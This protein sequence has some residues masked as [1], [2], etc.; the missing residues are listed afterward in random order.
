MTRE[1]RTQF[2]IHVFPYV[3][4]PSPPYSSAPLGGMQRLAGQELAPHHCCPTLGSSFKPSDTTGIMRG[5]PQ[6]SPPPSVKALGYPV[7]RDLCDDG[8]LS[9]WHPGFS[10]SRWRDEVV[11]VPPAPLGCC[12]VRAGSPTTSLPT[13]PAV[14][15]RGS[16]TGQPAGNS[17]RPFWMIP[18]NPA[19]FSTPGLG[20][21][22]LARCQPEKTGSSPKAKT[23]LP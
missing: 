10:I 23:T 7:G 5:E 15:E 3:G 2:S 14:M 21:A 12:L 19:S 17:Q 11:G 1:V 9:P 13:T 18:I 6:G 20:Q 22:S 8:P 16:S 4:W